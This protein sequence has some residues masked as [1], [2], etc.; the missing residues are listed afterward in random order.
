MA[1][2]FRILGVVGEICIAQFCFYLKKPSKLY[3]NPNHCQFIHIFML[4]VDGHITRI[5]ICNEK[6][7]FAIATN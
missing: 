1:R 2:N 3:Q 4:A 7:Q 6:E 5:C